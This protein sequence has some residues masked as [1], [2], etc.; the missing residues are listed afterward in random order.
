MF[1]NF[2]ILGFSLMFRYRA[3]VV[4]LACLMTRRAFEKPRLRI[5]LRIKKG[6]ENDSDIGD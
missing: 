2:G 4:K 5:K 6:W 3:A 1:P